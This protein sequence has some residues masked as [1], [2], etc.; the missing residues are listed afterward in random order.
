[1]A[2]INHESVGGWLNAILTRS[3]RRNIIP[4]AWDDTMQVMNAPKYSN[5][6]G[7]EFKD[8]RKAADVTFV[9]RV[10]PNFSQVTDFPTVVLETGCAESSTQLREDARL[11]QLGSMKAVR[12]AL[13]AKFYPADRYNQ[14]RF[15]FSISRVKP[16]SPFLHDH[17]QI[18]PRP[19][20]PHLNPSISFDEFYGGNCPQGITAVNKVVLDLGRL[21]EIVE[22]MIRRSGHVPA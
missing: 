18:F 19:A 11:W 13:L 1:M 3:S 20:T 4:D 8:T 16:G 17:Y 15:V 7:D 5:F 2:S 12:V 22:I 21:A 10:G 6:L 9:P 14:V